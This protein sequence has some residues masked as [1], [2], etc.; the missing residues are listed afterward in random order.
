[1]RNTLSDLQA[2]LN[3][4]RDVVNSI[5][6]DASASLADTQLRLRHETM[7]AA[8]VVLLSGFLESFLRSIAERFIAELCA[9]QPAF[10]SL[11]AEVRYAHYVEGGTVLAK[12]AAAQRRSSQTW[13][14]ATPADIA[15]RLHSIS[16][17]PYEIVWEA[18]AETRANPNSENVSGFVQK[19][20]VDKVWPKLGAKAQ[21]RSAQMTDNAMATALNELIRERNECAHSG[22]VASLPSP[23][24]LLGQCDLLEVLGESI[25]EVLEDHLGAIAPGSSRT[26]RVPVAL[27]GSGSAGAAT[28][29]V[30]TGAP[31]GGTAGP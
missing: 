30:A 19:F 31:T 11:P 25:V 14:V 10:Q 28:S 8:S 7:Q 26:A 27:A 22:S 21:A 5:L 1:M 2:S 13:I 4:V 20:G 16:V 6:A 24:Q 3:R 29:S 9:S 23:S 17:G 15:R 18:F 12:V